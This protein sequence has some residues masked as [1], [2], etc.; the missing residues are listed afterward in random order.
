M[1]G[2]PQRDFSP[3]EIEEYKALLAARLD[4]MTPAEVAAMQGD[5]A[6][7]QAF[8][9]ELMLRVAMKR[10]TAEQL[11]TMRDDVFGAEPSVFTDAEWDVM[12]TMPDSRG[13][14]HGPQRSAVEALMRSD[15]AALQRMK[16]SIADVQRERDSAMSPMA[17][18]WI[19]RIAVALVVGLI[20][21][22][23]QGK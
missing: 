13:L 3:E 17:K 16:R 19:L 23:N 18:Q 11:L 12:D 2:I 22:A 15:P 21:L 4:A 9:Q 1:T 8:T 14:R 5:H 6:A 20:I 7:T 10:M